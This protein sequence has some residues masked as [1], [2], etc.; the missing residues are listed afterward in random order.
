M[1]TPGIKLITEAIALLLDG[2]T[3][4][5]SPEITSCAT[6][7]CVSTRGLAPLT[8]MVSSSA[9]TR[10]S[11]FTV[12]VNPAVSTIPSRLTVLKPARLK[13]TV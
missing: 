6:A 1:D 11:P 8:V 5:N 13:V 7:F 2:S 12:A 3:D 4:S 10:R 9:P